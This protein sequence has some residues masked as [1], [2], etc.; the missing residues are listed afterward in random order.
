[1]KNIVQTFGLN[2][3]KRL[4]LPGVLLILVVLMVEF[5]KENDIMDVWFDSGTSHHAALKLKY[6]VE[7]ADVYA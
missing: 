4:L 7:Q 1:M 6:G 5:T 3:D 2:E